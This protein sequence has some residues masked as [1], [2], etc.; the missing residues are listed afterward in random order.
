MRWSAGSAFRLSNSS[1]DGGGVHPD[2]ESG[3]AVP[4]IQ[5]V[6]QLVDAL[7]HGFIPGMVA[8]QVGVNAQRDGVAEAMGTELSRLVDPADGALQGLVVETLADVIQDGQRAFRMAAVEIPDRVEQFALIFRRIA[9]LDVAEVDAGQQVAGWAQRRFLHHL[10]VGPGV[11]PGQA[12][13]ETR[14]DVGA[15]ILPVRREHRKD[16]LS[17]LGLGIFRPKV[18]AVLDVADILAALPRDDF[19]DEHAGLIDERRQRNRAGRE[20]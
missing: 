9:L 12:D 16:E 6:M 5:I 8:V 14:L 19:M 11:V 18:H 20:S 7:A 10:P 15:L 4:V 3:E 2:T 13:G 1:A 17:R